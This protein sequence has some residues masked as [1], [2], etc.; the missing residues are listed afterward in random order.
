[1][2]PNAMGM[3]QRT[4]TERSVSRAAVRHVSRA[5]VIMALAGALLTLGFAPGCS[6]GASQAEAPQATSGTVAIGGGITLHYIE[7][8]SGTPVVFVHGSLS[9]Y[10]YWRQQLESFS[11]Q[12]RAIAYSRRYNY[13]NS[14]P[15]Q[16]GYSAV[17][18]AEDLAAFI[19][20]QHLGKAYIVGHS[21][22]ALT[23]L[24]LATLHPELI[25][26]VVL[27]E[28]PA[29][30]LLRHLRDEQASK[31]AAMFADIR[32]R[33]V[34]P[35]KAHFAKG[36]R[37]AG[38]GDFIDYVF[39]EPGAWA[40]MSPSDRAAT[41]RDAHEWDVIMTT[42]ELFPEID[43]AA[44]ARIRVPVLVMSGGKSPPFLQYIDQ[45]LARLIPGSESIVY[46][47]AGH[48]MWYTSPVLCSNDVKVFFARHP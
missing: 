17:T 22:G 9:D 42:G 25:R 3:P 41:L 46:P 10:E 27:A 31:G 19:T 39:N 1:M 6:L 29:I 37:E 48:Q 26:S 28:P 18:D 38:V 47:D 14:N 20:R 35:M 16:P 12:Y 45:E 2:L 8:G 30:P 5:R 34:N 13:P 44:V 15:S 23:A 4:A 7:E 40:R 33:M 43:P 11:K 32:E 36:D 24:F 21:Y